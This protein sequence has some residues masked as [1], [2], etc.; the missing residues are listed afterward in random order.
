MWGE[1]LV[2]VVVLTLAAIAATAPPPAVAAGIDQPFYGDL[3]NDGLRDR[4]TSH[5]GEYEDSPDNWRAACFVSVA[6]GRPGGGHLPPVRHHW[7]DVPSSAHHPCPTMGTVADLGGDDFPEIVLAFDHDSDTP[8][9]NLVVLAHFR[10][11][12]NRHLG[13]FQEFLGTAD[14]D[15]DG[16]EDVYVEGNECGGFVGLFSDGA[17][18]FRPGE[19]TWPGFVQSI[20]ADFD[21]D[22][23]T[24][25][26]IDWE[27]PDWCAPAPEAGSGV[28]VLHGDGRIQHL[29]RRLTVDEW[30]LGWSVSRVRANNDRYHDVRTQHDN[31]R[32]DHH[33]GTAD[34]SFVRA[35]KLT[36]DQVYISTSQPV[37]INV[38]ANDWITTAAPVTIT[39]QPRY[40]QVTVTADRKVRYTPNPGQRQTDRFV[41][42]VT[43][44]NGVKAA[45]SVYVRWRG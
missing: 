15:G 36:G 34:G 18:Q 17:G 27:Y 26:V 6:Y 22:G 37:V 23:S 45:T 4:V 14:F 8:L 3:N 40:G 10:L 39:G 2:T 11:T 20:V 24:E 5:I 12:H 28:V 41:Y 9:R 44:A 7:I 13:E 30:Y 19:L 38:T 35:P 42:Q 16:R 31:G 32:V 29:E 25:A 43:E 1:R 33:L 21:G